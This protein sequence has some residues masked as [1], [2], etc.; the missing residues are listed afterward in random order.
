MGGWS[1]ATQYA[2]VPQPYRPTTGAALMLETPDKA[3]AFLRGMYAVPMNDASA[4][5]PAL[6]VA[7]ELLGSGDISRLFN[8]IR[9][10]EGL[11][12]GVGSVLSPSVI[13]ENS[14]FIFYAIFAPNVLPKVRTAFSEE[15]GRA[16]TDGYTSEEIEIGKRALLQERQIERSD[17]GALASSLVTQAYVGRT[18]DFA[19]KTDAAIGA[20]TRDQ[21][22]ATL[23]KYVKPGDIAYAYAGDFAKK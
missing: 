9:E 7:N 13:D 8:R 3:N 18:W 4:D 10:K 17:D 12:Y 2:R 6:L 1:S 20:L 11:S 22:N 5:F 19:A 21:V 16:V 14:K 15:I 23:R